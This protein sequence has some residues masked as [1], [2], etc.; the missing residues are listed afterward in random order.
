[1]SYNVTAV[2]WKRGWELHIEG[3]GVTQS[4][5]LESARSMVR[6]YL[7]MEGRADA[8]TAS[9]FVSPQLDDLQAAVDESNR[10]TAQAQAYQATAATKKREAAAALRAKGLSVADVATVMGV[11]KGRVSQLTS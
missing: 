3:V 4:H 6:D 11:S 5:T 10:L 7:E 1:M 8:Q 9:L 2:H